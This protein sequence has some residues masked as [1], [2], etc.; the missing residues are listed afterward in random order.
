MTLSLSIQGYKVQYWVQGS[1]FV[2]VSCVIVYSRN[3]NMSDYSIYLNITTSYILK[4]NERKGERIKS[5]YHSIIAL[6]VLIEAYR[7]CNTLIQH[8]LIFLNQD[9]CQESVLHPSSPFSSPVK[10]TKNYNYIQNSSSV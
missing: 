7:T 5:Q 6:T 3:N 8:Q 1:R 2:G 9:R 4:I 10:F